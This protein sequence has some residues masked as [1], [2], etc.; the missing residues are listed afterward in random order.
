[1]GKDFF[2]DVVT[3]ASAIAIAAGYSYIKGYGP[4]EP[5]NTKLSVKEERMREQEEKDT[6][7]KPQDGTEPKNQ[8]DEERK[9]P[10]RPKVPLPEIS[11]DIEE[12]GIRTIDIGIG[13]ENVDR[14]VVHEEISEASE[15]LRRYGL[16]LCIGEERDL[17][18]P[19]G[20]PCLEVIEAVKNS[21][22]VPQDFYIAVKEKFPKGNKGL[23]ALVD[24]GRRT[25]IFNG[26]S[27]LDGLDG[28]IVRDIKRIL[29]DKSTTGFL[30]PEEVL[31]DVSDKEVL[32]NVSRRLKETRG[33]ISRLND[34]RDINVGIWVDDID[35][36]YLDTLL[37]VV[38]KHFSQNYGINFTYEVVSKDLGDSFNLA[39]LMLGY[40]TFDSEVDLVGV[41]TSQDYAQV[42]DIPFSNTAGISDYRLGAFLSEING[43]RLLDSSVMIHEINHLFEV[44]HDLID[45][46]LMYPYA[47]GIGP[48]LSRQAYEAVWYERNKEWLISRGKVDRIKA[49]VNFMD[50][51]G[52]F[53]LVLYGYDD[54]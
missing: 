8:Q 34:P 40:R 14:D 51:K 54:E 48:K 11:G 5:T 27:G 2:W 9:V 31:G 33:Y 20:G 53:D 7:S 25:S 17:L 3:W 47:T 23:R 49:H 42:K 44:E 46:S 41:V 52:A 24:E 38:G 32:D 30:K 43:D 45:G 50:S 22:A 12:L 35:G 4:F 36:S 21:F 1:M 29:A 16:E 19:G 15:R 37:E 13:Y 28:F 18:M 39:K 10:E 26:S 6:P